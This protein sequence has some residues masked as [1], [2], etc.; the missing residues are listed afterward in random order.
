M[1]AWNTFFGQQ[2]IKPLVIG[3]REEKWQ[4]I[5]DK[6]RSPADKA[7]VYLCEDFFNQ[8]ISGF[9]G[10]RLLQLVG[11]FY[12]RVGSTMLSVSAADS[13]MMILSLIL[14]LSNTLIAFCESLVSGK[15]WVTFSSNLTCR[16][17]RIP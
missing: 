2:R 5:V 16:G 17:K 8:L 9:V 3:I 4:V 13:M 7:L 15:N 11:S 10:Q 1:I 12:Q 6:V 14:R